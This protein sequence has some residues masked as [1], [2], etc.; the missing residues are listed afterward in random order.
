MGKKEENETTIPD[1]RVV[2]IL[3]NIIVTTFHFTQN[4][5]EQSR[6]HFLKHRTEYVIDP[7]CAHC[8]SEMELRGVQENSNIKF[9]Y[10]GLLY[11]I[12]L[13]TLHMLLL[14]C[15]PACLYMTMIE[16]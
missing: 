8:K 16:Y 2:C 6:K 14:A 3:R 5:Q 12:L 4:I 13:C 11:I 1:F 9:I 15:L 7:S 10:V